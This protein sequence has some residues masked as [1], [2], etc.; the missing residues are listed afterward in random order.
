M[1]GDLNIFFCWSKI[2][3]CDHWCFW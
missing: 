1:Q 2:R 3:C